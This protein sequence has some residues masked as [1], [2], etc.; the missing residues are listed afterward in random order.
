MTDFSCRYSGCC[1]IQNISCA[2]LSLV[3]WSACEPEL[4][5]SKQ[6][7]LFHSVLLPQV[8]SVCRRHGTPSHLTWIITQT[9]TVFARLPP[10]GGAA[11]W[12]ITALQVATSLWRV[13]PVPSVTSLV[14]FRLKTQMS[15]Y[16]ALFLLLLQSQGRASWVSF[17]L[18][19]FLK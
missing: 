19:S 7:C 3:L 11:R 12:A 18:K 16:S 15:C 4:L 1:E 5:S 6:P 8:G 13:H 2:S 14:C 10:Q 17:N 9:P